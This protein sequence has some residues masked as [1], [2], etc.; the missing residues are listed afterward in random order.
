MGGGFMQ[1]KNLRR[2]KKGLISESRKDNML[3]KFF[4]L[5]IIVTALAAIG[6]GVL[7]IIEGQN[8]NNLFKDSIERAEEYAKQYGVSIDW[9]TLLSV[10]KDSEAENITLEFVTTGLKCLK[11]FG[12]VAC[13]A[14]I[15]AIVGIKLSILPLFSACILGGFGVFML[16]YANTLKGIDDLGLAVKIAFLF[17]CI[18]LLVGIMRIILKKK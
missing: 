4:G 14:G 3:R 12:L 8:A 10:Y 9:D 15:I 7:Y 11:L 18:F 5:I 6:L 16:K 1:E 17:A 13:I 2:T